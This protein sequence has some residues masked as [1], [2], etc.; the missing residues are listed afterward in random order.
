MGLVLRGAPASKGRVRAKVKVLSS[1]QD[2][3]KMEAGYV[4]VA[5]STNPEYT[6]AILKAAALVTDRGG[7]MC[8]AAIIAREMGIPLEAGRVFDPELNVKLGLFYLIEYGVEVRLKEP[9]D[10]INHCHGIASLLPRCIQRTRA[11]YLLS[12]NGSIGKSF[13]STQPGR[14]PKTVLRPPPPFPSSVQRTSRTKWGG[15]LQN[16]Y[17]QNYYS[18]F[19]IAVV[20]N[21]H[22]LLVAESLLYPRAKSTRR[23]VSQEFVC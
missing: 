2:I 1:S 13:Y 19:R 22:I 17:G 8:H 7:L 5:P 20:I 18:I 23:Q 12:R 10:A 11:Q 9:R 3:L 14:K 16:D 15:N 4:L 6:P 21:K